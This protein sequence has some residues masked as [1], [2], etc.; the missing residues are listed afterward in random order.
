[1]INRGEA[2]ELLENKCL[3]ELLDNMRNESVT[4]ITM[5]GYDEDKKRLAQA[6]RLRTIQDIK[7]ILSEQ[8]EEH[9]E[10]K[11]RAVV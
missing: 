5:A 1:M 7:R 3:N 6:E 9:S 2:K 11:T 8:A 10:N 4:I